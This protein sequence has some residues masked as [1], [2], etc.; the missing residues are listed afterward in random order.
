MDVEL[1]PT[2]NFE[3]MCVKPAFVPAMQPGPTC[4]APPGDGGTL[5]YFQL[6]YIDT[7]LFDVVSL[8]NRNAEM[9]ARRTILIR[10]VER[11]HRRRVEGVLRSAPSHRD[12]RE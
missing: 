3:K 6:F 2:F 4:V 11:H 12:E 10:A 5:E 7:F 8:T 9:S 1:L